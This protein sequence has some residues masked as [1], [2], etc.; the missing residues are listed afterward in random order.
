MPRSP[1]RPCRCPG[2]VELA[3]DGSVFCSIHKKELSIDYNRIKRNPEISKK[4][5]TTWKK[6]RKVY[7][8]RHPLCEDCLMFGR[9]VPAEEVHHIVPL[10][11]GGQNDINNLRSLCRSCH[12]KAH[13]KIGD[14]SP[15]R[16]V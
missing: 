8:E 12:V 11:A 6:L 9:H 7:F 5:G 15:G 14:R 10:S 16:G 4:Y 13:I 3:E 2:C 1:R